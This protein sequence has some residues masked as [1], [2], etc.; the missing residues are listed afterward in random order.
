[1][2]SKFRYKYTPC[3]EFLGSHYKII[4][5]RLPI[6]KFGRGYR[7]FELE[8]QRILWD[9]VTFHRISETFL[10]N[11]ISTFYVKRG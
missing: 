6:K 3:G 9:F 8:T 11:R 7:S 1:M 5:L 10:A 2:S 4:V